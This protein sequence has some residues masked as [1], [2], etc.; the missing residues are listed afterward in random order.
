[1]IAKLSGFARLRTEVHGAEAEA[2]D[3]EAGA[4]EPRELHAASVALF[5]RA[6]RDGGALFLG[7][8]AG[9]LSEAFSIKLWTAMAAQGPKQGGG[10]NGRADGTPDSRDA[11]D[12]D[13]ML[14][15]LEV[16]RPR[17]RKRRGPE[18]TPAP[19][20][21]AKAKAM[22]ENPTPRLPRAQSARTIPMQGA[23]DLPP[24]VVNAKIASDP[25]GQAF[26]NKTEERAP[27]RRRNEKT[28]LTAEVTPQKPTGYWSSALIGFIAV[29]AVGLIGWRIMKYVE[30]QAPQKTDTSDPAR[31]MVTGANATT[32]TTNANANANANANG[33]ANAAG[34]GAPA[35]ATDSTAAGTSAGAT[36]GATTQGSPE[37]NGQIDPLGRNGTSGAGG[38][39]AN[40]NANGAPR[41]ARSGS[42]AANSGGAASAPSGSATGKYGDMV[43]PQL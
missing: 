7:R 20:A 3:F 38:A 40:A 9:S 19:E 2:A 22:G 37:N 25:A 8:V 36:Q 28:M 24:D 18:F 14:N 13:D 35:T 23:P 15:A 5:L 43:A 26:L 1:M 6:E 30:S 21:I 16:S 41:T 12:V 32:T 29:M 31:A 17:E 4:S 10:D 11:H 34:T 42:G 27:S 39:R 33:T